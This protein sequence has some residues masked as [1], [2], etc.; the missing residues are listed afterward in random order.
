MSVWTRPWCL[1][2]A[3]WNL[4]KH[5]GGLSENTFVAHSLGLGWSRQLRPH[6]RGRCVEAVRQGAGHGDSG[7]PVE[8]GDVA[9][10]VLQRDLD[11]PLRGTDRP[12][13]VASARP[14]VGCQRCGKL[15]ED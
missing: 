4:A 8:R 13:R 10:A 12:C 9:Q 6:P 2:C 11:G 15:H 14:R 7:Q 5:R 3:A 1:A